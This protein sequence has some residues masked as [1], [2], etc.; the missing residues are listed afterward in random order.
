MTRRAR[1]TGAGMYVPPH[2]ITNPELSLRLGKPVPETVEKNLGI[3]QHFVTGAELSAAD[4]GV[5]AAKK[6]LQSAGVEPA[7][8]DLVIVTTDTPEYLSPATASVVQGRLGAV[9]A[10]TFDLNGACSGFAAALTVAARMIGYGTDYTRVLVIGVYNMSKFASQSNEFFAAV[11][12]DGGGAVVL[13][14]GAGDAGYLA[15]EMWADGRYHDYFGVFAG[16]TKYPLTQERLERGEQLLRIDKPYPPDINTANWPRLVRNVAVKAGLTVQDIDHI[17]FTQINRSSIE[18]V[19]AELGLPIAK[20]TCAMDTFGYTGSACL[21][22]ALCQAIQNEK[23]HRG[24]IV[25]LLG[26]GVGAAMAACIFKW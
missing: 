25:V 10:G 2:L 12:G 17:L 22:I 13:E 5:E 9:S 6:A 20:T 15:S 24:D 11:F 7:D 26:S 4:L 19:M 1:I 16:G 21:P 14:A 8:I 18:I 23:I 3:K